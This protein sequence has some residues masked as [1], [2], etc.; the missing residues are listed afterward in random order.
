MPTVLH[1]IDVDSRATNARYG[2]RSTSRDAVRRILT[3][4]FIG[5]DKAW[6]TPS[7]G[8]TANRVAAET[9]RT[10]RMGALPP[11]ERATLTELSEPRERGLAHARANELTQAAASMRL[12]RLLLGLARLSPAGRAYAETMQ[13]AAESYVSYQRRDYDT[14]FAEM[15]CAIDAANQL[16]SEWGECEFIVCRRID[17]G[18]NLMRVDMRRGATANA[19]SRGI[20]LLDATLA[21]TDQLGVYVAGL[22]CDLIASTMAELAAPLSRNDARKILA[23]FLSGFA[24]RAMPSARTEAWIA[25]KHGILTQPSRVDVTA[26][27]LFLA[28]GRERTPVLWYATAVDAA[29]ACEALDGDAGEDAADSIFAT[30]AL[31][32]RVPAGIRAHAATPAAQ[33]RSVA[34]LLR[35]AH[36]AFVEGRDRSWGPPALDAAQAAVETGVL[37]R[38]TSNDRLALARLAPSRERALSLA[39]RDDIEAARTSMRLARLTLSLADCSSDCRLYA[40]T[41]HEAAESYL[42]YRIGDFPAAARKMRSAIAITQELAKSWGDC[43][44]IVFRRVHLQHNLMRVHVASGASAEAMTIG[45]ALVDCLAPLMESETA[46]LFF[47][48][49][50]ATVAELFVRLTSAERRRFLTSLNE[51]HAPEKRSWRGWEWLTVASAAVVADPRPFIALAEAFLRGGRQC[52]PTLWYAVAYELL[53]IYDRFSSGAAAAADLRAELGTATGVPGCMRRP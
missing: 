31:A 51:I 41:L 33:R 8:P 2:A 9:K 6:S 14:A 39:R 44:F 23:P 34:T 32:E 42:A 37:T 30:L 20:S 16:G 22:L 7:N 1:E 17:L 50:I 13:S 10:L 36:E 29:R 28:A 52:A 12:A 26:L 11:A 43:P 48:A 47:N 49:V 45:R 5:R 21:A 40:Q 19:V 27:E 3:A 53:A 46:E 38:L 35:R 25:I 18:H 4:F 24:A 15:Q